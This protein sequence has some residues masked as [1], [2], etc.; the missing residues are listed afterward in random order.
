[1]RQ[2]AGCCA[3]YLVDV[4]STPSER[5]S[6]SWFYQISID[7]LDL[8]GAEMD[9]QAPILRQSETINSVLEGQLD[10][11]GKIRGWNVGEPPQFLTL[12]LQL[13]LPYLP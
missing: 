3:C 2:E 13:H 9:V 11:P 4:S 12:T 5:R 10:R 1:M 7:L 8:L 6:S